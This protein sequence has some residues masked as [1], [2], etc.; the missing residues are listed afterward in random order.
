MMEILL[1][2]WNYPPRRGGIETMM[3]A[4]RAGL[5]AE[6]QLRVI[7]AHATDRVNDETDVLRAPFPGLCA[8]AIY[9]FLR[10]A[11]ELLGRPKL[12]IVFGGSALTTPLVLLLARLFRRKAVIQVHGLDV[13]HPNALYRF[14][15]V[16]WLRCCDLVIAN[17]S[18]TAALARQSG[19]HPALISVIPPGV[20]SKFFTPGEREGLK[21]QLRLGGKR[22]VLFVGRL[23]ERKGVKEFIEYALPR[24]LGKIPEVCFVVVGENA[25]ASLTRQSD[26]LKEIRATIDASGMQHQVQLVGAVSDDALADFYRVCD[27]VVLPAIL[28]NNDIEGFGMVLLEAAAAGKPAIATRVG[29]IPDAIADGQSGVLCAPGDH[30]RLANEVM[31]LL[32]D[33]SRRARMGAAARQRAAAE[34]GWPVIIKKYEMAFEGL[35]HPIVKTS[36]V[37]QTI[38][39]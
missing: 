27:L 17:S 22:I 24:I 8:F 11:L 29:G 36:Q 5:R 34:F 33:Q 25:A 37:K 7:T 21:Q 14:L 12:K 30:K 23:V 9:A 16:R 15:C 32:Q 26:A 4:L 28:K 2:T 31:A 3:A 6:N 39:S 35:F 20:D 19:V 10:G 18:Y 1:I 13:A 38:G